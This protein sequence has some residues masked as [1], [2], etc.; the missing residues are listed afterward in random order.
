M[1]RLLILLLALLPAIFI[2]NKLL[3]QVGE[4]DSLI[5][6]GQVL[7]NESYTGL[8]FAHIA[9]NN[10]ATTTDFKGVFKARIKATDTLSVSYVGYKTKLVIVPEDISS[11][12][13]ETKVLLEKDT[14]MMKDAEISMLPSSIEAFKQAILSLELTDQEYKNVEKNMTA[15]TQQ[16]LIYDYNKYTMDAAENQRAAMAGPQSFN[17]M[18]VLKKVKDALTDPNKNKDDE[19]LPPPIYY[20]EPGVPAPSKADSLLIQKSDTTLRVINN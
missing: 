10:W 14:I 5:V 17:F 12:V 11:P 3:A 8:P 6:I 13:F 16:V 4:A 19:L 18:G 2:G 20:E 7:E 1:R 15:L 9:I